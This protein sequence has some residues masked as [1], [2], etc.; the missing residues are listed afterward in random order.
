MTEKPTSLD[1]ESQLK[2]LE[3]LVEKLESGDLSLEESLKAY[4]Q[5]VKISQDCE[6][7]LESAQQRVEKLLKKDGDVSREP[8]DT[9]LNGDEIVLDTSE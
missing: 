6:A 7:A 1:F 9:S 5:G 2:Q 8:F 3:S 4:E